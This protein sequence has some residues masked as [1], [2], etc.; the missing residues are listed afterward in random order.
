VLGGSAV[1]LFDGAQPGG[2]PGLVGGYGLAVA[3]AGGAL[4]QASAG[5]FDLAE[6]GF[7]F[8]GEGSDGDH[9]DV[10]DDNHDQ[11]D[12]LGLGVAAGQGEDPGAV[13]VGPGLLGMDAALP[14]R[15][16]ELGADHVGA[17]DLVA[18]GGEL[19]PD[20]AEFG[21]SVIAAPQEPCGLGS[22]GVG[23]A[24]VLAQLRPQVRM[25]G[26]GFDL[27]PIVHHHFPPKTILPGGLTGWRD[28]WPLFWPTPSGRPP[29]RAGARGDARVVELEVAPEQPA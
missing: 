16:V 25:D 24:G 27:E 22:V 8:V 11:A 14:D 1:G 9:D 2:D 4:G 13:G 19:L 10:G 21:A 20:R 12:R 7:A 15:V 26:S 17:V 29:W 6:V 28:G 18:G 5:S 23:A 3:A